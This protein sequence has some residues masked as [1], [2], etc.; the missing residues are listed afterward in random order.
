MSKLTDLLFGRYD[1]NTH[2]DVGQLMFSPF[3]AIK[4]IVGEYRTGKESKTATR[5]EKARGCGAAIALDILAKPCLYLAIY[6][7]FVSSSPLD[8]LIQYCL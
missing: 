1:R 5:S 7:N 8:D 6:S 4:Q 3:A 2:K